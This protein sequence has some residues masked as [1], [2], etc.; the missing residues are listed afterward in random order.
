[1]LSIGDFLTLADRFVGGIFEEGFY[2]FGHTS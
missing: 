1:M 2:A